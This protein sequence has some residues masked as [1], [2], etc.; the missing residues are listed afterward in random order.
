MKIK[1]KKLIL[2]VCLLLISAVMAGTASF[3]WFSMNTE[4]SVDGI[5]VEA[6][7]DSL[8]LEISTAKD[9]T[10]NTSV[11]LEGDKQYL[12]L[13]KHGF[14]SEAFTVVATPARGNY[15]TDIETAGTV[16]YKKVELNDSNYKYVIV[17]D[18]ELP[19]SDVEGLYKNA[20]FVRL[21]S[22]AIAADGTTYYEKLGSKYAPKTLTAGESAAGYY[23]LSPV[24]TL[25]D[26]DTATA[27]AG[28]VYYELSGGKYVVVEDVVVDDTLV[29]DY[30]TAAAIEA[31]DASA[32]YDAT[33]TYYKKDANNAFYVVDPTT[34][35]TDLSAY[36]T[37]AEDDVD[38]LT[39]ATG[40]IFVKNADDEYSLL[41]NFATAT[42]ITNMLYFGRAYSDV[43]A[44]GDSDDALN[45][46]KTANLANYRYQNSVYLHNANNTNDSRNLEASFSVSGNNV[47][48]SAVRVVLVVYDVTGTETFVNYVEYSKRTGDVNYLVGE[49]IV[50]LL[51]GN[52]AQTLRADIYVYYDGS[53]AAAKNDTDGVLE[54]SGN[55]VEIEFTIDGPDYN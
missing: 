24:Y 32:T 40:D 47:L 5:E 45:I 42:D 34:A 48:T 30:Y 25:I 43:I 51:A 2:A 26:D 23:T 55:K 1:S 7:S 18:L 14:V 38:D 3:A 9:G 16:F 20:T 21:G 12:R 11:T 17:S 6:Y 31:E 13:A 41:G 37:I 53:D 35:G 50:D 49:N 22:G 29:G 10:Y 52:E 36:F 19:T 8:F 4:V 33:A 15:S 27:E 44:D 28:V 46:V 39:A 54:L